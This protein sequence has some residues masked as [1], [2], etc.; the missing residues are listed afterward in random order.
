MSDENVSL[1]TV[2]NII[3]ILGVVVLLIFAVYGWNNGFFSSLDSLKLFVQ[4]T[5][6][7]GPIVFIIV[8]IVQV[9]IPIIPS[10][11]SLL[12][13]VIIFGPI[14]GFIYNYIGIV[15]GSIIAFMLTRRL[16][17]AFLRSVTSKKMYEKFV[18]WLG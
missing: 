14:E 5:G 12:A 15:V 7:W 16:G 2:Y 6:V 1:K 8:Q 11:I 4:K 18:C 9:V 17:I 10:G 3:S 13:G